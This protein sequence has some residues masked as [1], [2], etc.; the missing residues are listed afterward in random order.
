MDLQEQVK[1]ILN[2]LGIQPNWKGYKMWITAIKLKKENEYL[3]MEEIYV[4]VAKRHK[5]TKHKAERAMRYAITEA[6][7][8]KIG[9]YF[10]LSCKITN[11]V[12]LEILFDRVML[13]VKQ[14]K[15]SKCV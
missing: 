14:E 8:Q 7:K 10:E 13:F 4:E 15:M 6:G 1:K 2:E 11:S 9:K 5:S 12:F 3:K